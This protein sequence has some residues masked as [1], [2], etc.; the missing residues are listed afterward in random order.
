MPQYVGAT[1]TVKRLADLGFNFAR[2]T[3]AI[4]MIDEI[5]ENNGTDITLERAFL[6]GLGSN[7][8]RVLQEILDKNA[9]MGW[10]KET[11]RLQVWDSLAKL[12]AE[13]GIVM[14]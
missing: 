11:T 13:H 12:E 5:Y 2:H 8:T 6:N 7:G 1:T 10:T 9:D 14:Q 4:Q 3:Y